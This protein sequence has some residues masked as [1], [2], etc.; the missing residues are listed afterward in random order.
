VVKRFELKAAA[1]PNRLRKKLA[2]WFSEECR[3]Q[4]A[5]YKGL[6]RSHGRM[7]AETV[8]ALHIFSKMCEAARKKFC[9][10]LP[11]LLKY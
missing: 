5:I 2:P 6:I 9:L 3:A 4:K 8:E 10:G 7:A 11:S 1:N